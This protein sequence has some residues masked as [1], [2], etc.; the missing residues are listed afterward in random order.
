[1]STIVKKKAPGY[2]NMALSSAKIYRTTSPNVVLTGTLMRLIMY[3][4]FVVSSTVTREKGNKHHNFNYSGIKRAVIFNKSNRL[5]MTFVH[6]YSFLSLEKVFLIFNIWSTIFTTYHEVY[7][8]GK[9]QSGFK[10]WSVQQK[11]KIIMSASPI[12]MQET[13]FSI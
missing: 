6:W 1:M 8:H 4:T 2:G 9:M 13:P 7:S 5:M 10:V 11:D 12:V 3:T